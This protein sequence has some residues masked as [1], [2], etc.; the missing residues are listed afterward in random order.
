MDHCA[1]SSPLLKEVTNH[2]KKR[3]ESSRLFKVIESVMW[4]VPPQY[5]PYLY[6]QTAQPC[7]H[8]LYPRPGE[9]VTVERTEQSFREVS[10]E[11]MG[12]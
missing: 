8:D 3:E 1:L 2:L 7:P 11:D 4:V 12:I 9:E 10:R 5:S 6:P